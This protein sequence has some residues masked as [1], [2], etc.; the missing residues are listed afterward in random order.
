MKWTRSRPTWSACRRR[1]AG[2][3][4]TNRPTAVWRPTCADGLQSGGKRNC[5][6]LATEPL[7][8]VE[9]DFPEHLGAQGQDE[10]E[11]V[12]PLHPADRNADELP[13]RVEHAAA[14][15]TWMAVG[16]TGDEVVGRL[17]ADVA[18]RQN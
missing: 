5:R 4:S 13:V 9:R 15:D 12:I 3:R 10:R 7:E 1:T 6:S 8:L 16:Q 17:L 14:R 18:A 11:P 2:G